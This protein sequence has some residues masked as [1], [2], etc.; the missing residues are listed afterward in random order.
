MSITPIKNVEQ[1]KEYFKTMGCSHFHMARE[2]PQRYEEYKQLNISSQQESEW[3][4]EQLDEY[5]EMVMNKTNRNPFWVVHSNMAELA[6]I[7]RTE[8]ALEKVLVVTQHIREAAP[9]R[10][11]VIVSETINGRKH[12]KFRSGLIYLAFDLKKIETAKAFTE[13]SLYFA[14]ITT[15]SSQEFNRCEQASKLTRDIKTELG[16]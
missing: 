5:Y 11:K 1:A 6:E 16:L 9:F 12:R 2:Y 8:D 15:G 10:E 13:L 3:R 14:S 4:G 7:L